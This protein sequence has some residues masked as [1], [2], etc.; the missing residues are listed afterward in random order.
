MENK[1]NSITML[2]KKDEKQFLRKKN[3]MLVKMADRAKEKEIMSLRLREKEQEQ[4]L[5]SLKLKEL[6]RIIKQHRLRPIVPKD[7]KHKNG[8]KSGRNKSLAT[9]QINQAEFKTSNLQYGNHEP[10][11]MQAKEIDS[12]IALR[13]QRHKLAKLEIKRKQEKSKMHNSYVDLRGT[14]T[15][16]DIPTKVK[17]EFNNYDEHKTNNDVEEPLEDLHEIIVKKKNTPKSK[18]FTNFGV[19]KYFS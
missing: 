10:E 7:L 9:I 5:G 18:I 13:P 3:K 8:F 1:I 19:N 15:R 2:I 6:K 12:L 11:N 14:T 16:E 4:R 17:N